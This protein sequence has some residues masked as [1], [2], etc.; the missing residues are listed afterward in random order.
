MLGQDRGRRDCVIP[1]SLF[2]NLTDK[3]ERRTRANDIVSSPAIPAVLRRHLL[4]SNQNCVTSW[5]SSYFIITAVL[6][7]HGRGRTLCTP[8][9]S[10][11]LCSPATRPYRGPRRLRTLYS[12]RQSNLS[13]VVSYH[14][15]LS[16]YFAHRVW[17]ARTCF[18]DS[19]F[20]GGRSFLFSLPFFSFLLFST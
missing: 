20:I 13:A 19:C 3:Y 8:I 2:L 9:L 11:T 6:Q 4:S 14:I 12:S 16:C 15:I 17:V 1:S 10:R 5:G 18:L 7:V